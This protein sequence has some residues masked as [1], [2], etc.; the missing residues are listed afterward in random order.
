M[1]Y[2]E[3]RIKRQDAKA[4]KDLQRADNKL[5]ASAELMLE[6]EIQILQM[7]TTQPETPNLDR[8][9]SQ[10]NSEV[11]KLLRENYGCDASQTTEGV[12]SPSVEDQVAAKQRELEKMRET[13]EKRQ[14]KGGLYIDAVNTEREAKAETK[15]NEILNER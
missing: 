5:A 6:K 8:L 13:K 7:R 3:W 9:I 10:G 14:Q 1:G 15:I 11:D 4:Q 2:K 12:K